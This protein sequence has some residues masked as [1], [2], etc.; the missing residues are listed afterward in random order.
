MVLS[1]IDILHSL[2]AG[3][4]VNCII[5]VEYPAQSCRLQPREQPQGSFHPPVA[6]GTAPT[7]RNITGTVCCGRRPTLTTLSIPALNGGA[8]RTHDESLPERKDSSNS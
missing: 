1:A 3:K 6:K 5:G 2:K 4:D 7:S 8:F